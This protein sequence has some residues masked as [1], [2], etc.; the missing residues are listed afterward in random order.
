MLFAKTMDLHPVVVILAI[1]FFGDIWGFW[2]VFF[3][4]PLATLVHVLLEEWPR[5]DD[6]EEPMNVF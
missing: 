5:K 3:A 6:V 2:G 4:I 1:L